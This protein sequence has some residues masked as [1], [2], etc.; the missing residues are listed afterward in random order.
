MC[1][2]LRSNQGH[3]ENR[4]TYIAHQFRLHLQ[5]VFSV[6]NLMFIVNIRLKYQPELYYNP[7]CIG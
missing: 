1:S 7:I 6:M 4:S 2:L 5:P 3:V